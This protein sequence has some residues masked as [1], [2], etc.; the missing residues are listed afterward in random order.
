MENNKDYSFI[1]QGKLALPYQYFAGAT[2]SKFLTTLRDEGKI[3]G[4][5]DPK[6]NEVFIPPRSQ[7]HVTLDDISGNWVELSH[8]GTIENFTVVRYKGAYQTKEPPYILALIMLDGASTAFPHYVE[9]VPFD[10]VVIGMRVQA[11]FKP[12]EERT[13]SILDIKYFKT[14]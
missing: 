2:G 12:K 13:A 1:V 7:N 9:G 10:E 4:I 14:L 3:L 8:Q 11:V 5:K 6:T